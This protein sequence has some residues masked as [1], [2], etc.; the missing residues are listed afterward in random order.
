MFYLIAN[1]HSGTGRAAKTL[2]TVENS[3]KDNRID[4]C[5]YRTEYAGHAGELA[6]KI[7]LL[8]GEKT[9][10]ILGGDG[11]VNEVI[12][13]IEDFATT[14][15]GLVP[16]GS[17][18]DFAAGLGLKKDT[19]AAIKRIIDDNGE[20]L[21]DIGRV[22]F[23]DETGSRLF[24][25]SSGVGMDAIVCKKAQTSKSKSVLN[26]IGLGKLTYLLITIRTL[27]D[28]VN[29]TARISRDG[30]KTWKYRRMIFAAAMNT[31]AEGGGVPMAPK[32]KPDSGDLTLTMAF[33]IS[34]ALSIFVLPFL[35]LAK[36][37]K[38]KCFDVKTFSKCT[39]RLDEPMTV[40]A[41]GEYCG[42]HAEIEYECI[43]ALMRLIW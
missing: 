16:A 30:G 29:T 19:K 13:G 33:A 18:N 11:T 35:V 24:A 10:V 8:P 23:A 9:L 27:I 12:N 34:K 41:D 25:I 3:L 21:I 5:V 6:K 22:S 7:S 38:M 17:G 39:I 2:K 26:R 43:P 36:H 37:E 1:V 20:R 31:F 42:E 40:H 4:Y 15:V 28:M 32:A 14:R